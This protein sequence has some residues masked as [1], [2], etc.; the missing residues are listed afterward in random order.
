MPW[1]EKRVSRR[2]VLQGAAVVG[3]GVATI[4]ALGSLTSASAS[5]AAVP[6]KW[7]KAA[8][9][10]VIGA[11]ATG[12]PAAIEAIQNKASVIL[13]EANSDVG[14]HAIVS[15]GNIPL[16][17]GTSAQKRNN[18]ADSPDLLFAD[19]TDWSVVETKGSLITDTTTGRSFAPLPITALRLLSGSHPMEWCLSTG[20][21]TH[22]AEPRSGTRS[23]EK[24]MRRQWHGRK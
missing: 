23:P 6:A 21:R 22:A 12:L 11:G 15:G 24:C 17:G 5:D 10:V 20:R 16:G 9:V 2:E 7:D 1:K 13:I 4:S 3:A 19:L 14:G 8:D 18:I